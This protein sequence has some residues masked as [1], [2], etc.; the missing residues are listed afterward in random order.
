[1]TPGERVLVLAPV[2]RDTPLLCQVLVRAGLDAEPCS[3]MDDLVR[4]LREGAGAVLLTEEALAPAAAASLLAALAAEPPWA[5]LPIVLLGAGNPRAQGDAVATLRAASNLTILERPVRGLSLVT[6]LQ[7]ALKA[8]R[9]QYEIRDWIQRERAAR[10]EAEA[11]SQIKDEFL[12]TVSHELRTPMG[13]ILLWAR[14]LGSGRLDEGKAQHA[15]LAIERSAEAQSKLIEDLLDVSRM[16]SGKLHLSLCEA[17]LWPVIHAAVDVIRPAAEA[18]RIAL[19][20]LLETHAG[21]VRIDPDRIRQ[22]IW[23]LL[24]NAVKFTPP[25]GRISIRLARRSGHICI[26]VA[27]TGKGIDPRFLPYVFER[28][29]QADATAHRQQGGLGLGLSISRQ[30]IELHGGTIC[31]ESAGPGLG[32]VFRVTLPLASAG[33][34]REAPDIGARRGA[35]TVVADR[36]LDGVRVLIVEDDTDT[37]DAIEQALE[38]YG[39]SVTAVESASAAL[40]AL[41]AAGPGKRPH[42]LLSDIGLPSMDG[43]ELLR[44]IRAMEGALGE[45]PLPAAMITAY[46]RPDDHEQA[47]SAG[48]V[49]HLSKPIEPEDLAALVLQLAGGAAPPGQGSPAPPQP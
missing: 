8:R 24:S 21:V 7:M 6:T 25:E 34:R 42:V 31:A 3:D 39:A 4:R 37:R 35:G 40:D 43:Y 30:L 13:A 26:E 17:D 9:R 44:R 29:R 23:N 27:D 45:A 16:T 41:S 12:A 20:A 2:G 11:A 18:K 5:E 15:I 46:A 28:F 38:Q 47:L 49:A 32:A 1:M 36:P 33:E 10:R 19:E 22:V 48:F 14:L